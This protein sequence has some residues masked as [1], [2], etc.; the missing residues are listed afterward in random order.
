VALTSLFPA[1]HAVDAVHQGKSDSSVLYIPVCP[2]TATNAEYLAR[3]R[4][5]F[6][7]GYPGPDFPGGKG[8]SEHFGR[9]T[10]DYLSKNAPREALQAMGLEKLSVTN[11][12]EGSGARSVVQKA[13]E[14]LGF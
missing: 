2:T 4:D 12:E 13:N 1:I 5:T 10:V 14:I 8:E 7:G 11:E 9:P 3:Q 6:L